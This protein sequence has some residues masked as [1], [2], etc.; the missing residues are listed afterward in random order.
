MPSPRILSPG[1]A[2]ARAAFTIL[3]K[4][5][6]K[7]DYSFT[8]AIENHSQQGYQVT[9]QLQ[10]KRTIVQVYYVTVGGLAQVQTY[11][12]P[13]GPACMHAALEKRSL[14]AVF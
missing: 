6:T 5:N 7:S 14:R 2:P 11:H 8:I 1:A 13:A 4:N 9:L 12:R 3:H 10:Y